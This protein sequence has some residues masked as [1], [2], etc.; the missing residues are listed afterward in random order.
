MHESGEC[1]A[2]LVGRA[3]EGDA[4][5]FNALVRK[6]ARAALAVAMSV[7]GNHADAEDVCQDAWVRALEKLESCRDPARFVY[8][9]LQIVRNRSLN[10]FAYRKLRA[11]EP[12]DPEDEDRQASAHDGSESG[13]EQRLL[14]TQI[15]NAI[16]QLHPSHRE[17]LLLHDLVGWGHRAIAESLGISE[18][19]CRQRLFQARARLRK[20]LGEEGGEGRT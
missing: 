14:R 6:H 16:G 8:W 19:L 7:L 17:V 5:A 12:L 1:D 13:M 2:T 3:R 10:Y 18:V 4:E 15:E 9:F 11:A 20:I